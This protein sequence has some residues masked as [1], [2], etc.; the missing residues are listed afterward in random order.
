MYHQAVL[1]TQTVY[2]AL[3]LLRWKPK[4]IKSARPEVFVQIH[5]CAITYP[6]H[7]KLATDAVFFRRVNG[8]PVRVNRQPAKT[9]NTFFLFF[10]TS[11]S[12][13]GTDR[14][15]DGMPGSPHDRSPSATHAFALFS[16]ACHSWHHSSAL[17]LLY[18]LSSLQEEWYS[19]DLWFNW[20]CFVCVFILFNLKVTAC[21]SWLGNVASVCLCQQY[22]EKEDKYEEEIKVLTDKL[23]E[24][25]SGF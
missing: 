11:H 16:L 21:V 23:K 24:V 14:Q 10:A 2:L 15:F 4:R 3:R 17:L 1:T 19:Y 12:S 9:C 5:V 18:L 20:V 13:P 6:P 25:R 7:D 22:S 8:V